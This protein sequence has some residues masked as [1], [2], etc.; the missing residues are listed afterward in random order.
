MTKQPLRRP[1][2]LGRTSFTIME[3]ENSFS[4]FNQILQP[5]YIRRYFSYKYLHCVRMKKGRL[6]VAHIFT[7]ELKPALKRRT[8]ENLSEATT[9][10]V[11]S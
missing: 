7:T 10:F 8:C 4:V 11:S 9:S 1:P 6:I 5:S 2:A 3:L